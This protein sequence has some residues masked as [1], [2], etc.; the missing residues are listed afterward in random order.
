MNQDHTTERSL[1]L[2][3]ETPSQNKNGITLNVRTVA[4]S[5]REEKGQMEMTHGIGEVL[6]WDAMFGRQF[7]NNLSEGIFFIHPA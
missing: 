3:S 5:N 2:Q 1:G 6:F 7:H 4:A